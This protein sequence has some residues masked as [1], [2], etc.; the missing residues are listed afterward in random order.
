MALALAAQSEELQSVPED[1]EPDVPRI[2]Y[3]ITP[4]IANNPWSEP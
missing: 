4:A 2:H 1:P 3:P